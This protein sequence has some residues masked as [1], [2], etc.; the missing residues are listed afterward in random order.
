MGFPCVATVIASVIVYA[1]W[2]VVHDGGR[3]AVSWQDV[4]TFDFLPL[5]AVVLFRCVC[6]AVTLYTLLSV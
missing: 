3:A 1:L 4:A 5:G 2:S 6:A